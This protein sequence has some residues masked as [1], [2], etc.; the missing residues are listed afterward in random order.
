MALKNCPF[1]G[2]EAEMGYIRSDSLK[3]ERFIP[4]CKDTKG[5]GRVRGEVHTNCAAEKAWNT[6]A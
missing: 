2:G 3:P 5:I 4:R 1:C 6:R